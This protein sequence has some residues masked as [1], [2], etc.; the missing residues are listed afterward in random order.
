LLQALA[1]ELQLRRSE[2][3][4]KTIETIYFGGGTPSLLTIDELR[5]LIDEVYTNFKVIDNPEITLEANPDDLTKNQILEL[6][7]SPINR[8]SIGVQSFFEDDLK[9]MNRAHNATEAKDCLVEA[10]KHFD[11]ITIDLIYGIPNMSI[12]KWNENLELAFSFGVNHISSYAL[13]VE[14]KTALDAFIKKGTYPPMDEEL[15][16]QHFN[17]LI[18]E[19]EKEGLVHYEISNFGKPDYFSK[20]NTS[21]WQGKQYLGIGPSAH[22]F[23][24]KQRSWN[25]A[26]NA[27]YIKSIQQNELPSTVETLSEQDRFNEYVMTGLRTIWGISL[28]KIQDDF[29]ITFNQNLLKSVQPYLEKNLLEIKDGKIIATQKGKFLIDGIASDLFMI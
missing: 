27:K 14:P 19:T 11:N 3:Q 2:L 22:S 5:F 12:E 9:S 8:L 20:H 7:R 25:V 6:S 21:Y 1:N 4:N 18:A 26:N 29:G 10:T 28:E 15:A 13:T 24:G 17:H 23:S 16:L